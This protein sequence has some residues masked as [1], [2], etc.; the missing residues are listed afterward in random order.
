MGIKIKP[1]KTS[2]TYRL[3]GKD[4]TEEE[5]IKTYSRPNDGSPQAKFANQPQQLWEQ[6]LEYSDYPE[7]IEFRNKPYVDG[8]KQALVSEANQKA[9]Y[10]RNLKLTDYSNPIP[11]KQEST[12]VKKTNKIYEKGTSGIKMSKSKEPKKEEVEVKATVDTS[13]EPYKKQLIDD[14]RKVAN[15]EALNVHGSGGKPN[16]QKIRKKGSTT[17]TAAGKPVKEASQDFRGIKNGKKDTYSKGTK[18]IKMK[19]KGC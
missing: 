15:G 18:G 7:D 11:I 5:L 3:R 2:K 10:I 9:N 19:K 1:P 12:T 4:Y 13:T 8:Y 17:H 6:E 16:A 14:R